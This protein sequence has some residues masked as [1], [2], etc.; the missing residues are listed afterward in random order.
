MRRHYYISDDL[1]DL[2][3]LEKE[4]EYAGVEKPQFHVL[5]NNDAGV[6]T[7]HLHAVE[8]V[9]K[10][11]VVYKTEI[12]FV[13]G[14]VAAIAV[15]L[16]GSLSGITETYTWVP[17]IFLAVVV[18]G[19]CTW[20]GGFIGT[21]ETHHDFVRFKEALDAGRH[22]FMVDVNKNQESALRVIINAHPR[23]EVAGEGRSTPKIVI[24][25]QRGFSR[26]AQWGP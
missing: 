3:A 9:L 6:D 4:L 15:L 2:E 22:V 24:D 5:S 23:M 19:F 21:Q 25:A 26:F 20:E 13:V 10:S 18:L 17:F 11:D 12:G 14:L 8:A 1:D 16:V 7:H